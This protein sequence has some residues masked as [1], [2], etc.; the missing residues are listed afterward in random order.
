ML[1]SDVGPS[2]LIFSIILAS[3]L[4]CHTSCCAHTACVVILHLVAQKQ[5]HRLPPSSWADDMKHA[6]E[7]LD[8]LEFCGAVDTVA[9]RFRVRLSGI[10]NTLSTFSAAEHPTT[11]MQRV[12]DWVLLSPDA[13]SALDETAATS[14]DSS[15]PFTDNDTSSL[16]YLFTIPP[17]ANPQLLNLSFSLL[18]A[19][20]RPWSNDNS[21][22]SSP[23]AITAST[24]AP[25]N[26]TT[27]TTGT[28]FASSAPST[29]STTS[30]PTVM[31][32][33]PSSQTFSATTSAPTPVTSPPSRDND[34]MQSQLIDRLKWDFGHVSPFRWDTDGMGMLKQGEVVAG[35]RP[36]C[37]LDS[38]A[39]SGWSPVEDFEVDVGV[40]GSGSA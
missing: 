3:I 39:P 40:E 35:G 36:S 8:V 38:E 17:S 13:T 25:T 9:L 10:F 11:A 2:R 19:L 15:S 20:C 34:Q 33:E 26:S 12:E 21:F 23:P 29:T 5:L 1:D 7:C 18:F 4:T 22:N 14:P 6:Q 24:T 28:S 32:S 31:K 27:T 30:T 16:D 37:F